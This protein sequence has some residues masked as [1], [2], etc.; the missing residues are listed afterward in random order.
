MQIKTVSLKQQQQQNRS[1]RG[2]LSGNKTLFYVQ[3]EIN[4]MKYFACF[5]PSYRSVDTGSCG[6]SPLEGVAD[7]QQSGE[8]RDLH[9]KKV[10][11]LK[12]TGVELVTLFYF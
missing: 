6:V 11:V 5:L 7:K 2:I 8:K 10:T 12:V 3:I 4:G 9:P 1:N